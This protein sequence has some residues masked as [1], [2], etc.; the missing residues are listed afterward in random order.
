[1]LFPSAP[2]QQQPSKV[3]L[4]TSE[5]LFTVLTAINTCGYDQELSDSDPVRAQVRAEVARAVEVSERAQTAVQEMCRFYREHRQQDATHDLAQYVSLALYLGEPPSFAPTVK[6]ADMPPDASYVLGFVPLLQRFYINTDLHQ[7]WNRRQPQYEALLDKFSRPVAE[8]LLTTDVYL[9]MPISGYVGRR[10]V[11]YLEPMAGPGQVNA[12][13]YG[14]DYF[15]VVAPNRG[16]L[17][18]APIR[19]TYLHFVTDPLTAKRATAMKRLDPIMDSVKTAP[20]DETFKNNVSLMVTESLIRA[21]EARMDV[22]GRGKEAEAQRAQRAQQ[23]AAEGFVLAPYFNQQL[24]QFEKDPEGL[25]DAF[26]TWLRMIDVGGERKKAAEIIFAN[27][28]APEAMHASTLPRVVPLVDQAEQ[29]LSAGD[30]GGARELA[31]EALA[32]RPEDAARAL[33]VLARVATLNG[34][35]NSAQAYFERTLNAGKDPKLVAWSH[36]YLGRIY[37]LKAEREAALEHYRAAL[38]SGDASP[39]T[40]AAAERGLQQPY[41][42]PVGR[43]PQAED[44]NED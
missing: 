31:Q 18:I 37:D 6:E 23:S 4:D 8:M 28:A 20:M 7:I 26:P 30:L 40:R 12:R 17:H 5:T 38:S 41:A 24:A 27:V 11:V 16:E 42:P 32:K 9:K 35:M 15:M 25:K 34:D 13:N 10:F 39:G 33:F 43:A 2:A 19:H 21:L 44:K 36:I 3:A 29:R 14:V 22:K 1:M